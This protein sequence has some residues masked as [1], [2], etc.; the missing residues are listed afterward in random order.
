MCI[1]VAMAL[2]CLGDLG[3][4][5]A[6]DPRFSHRLLLLKPQTDTHIRL[7]RV[8]RLGTHTHI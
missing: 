5:T 2:L 4:V 6:S 3:A 7:Y 8:H 1:C